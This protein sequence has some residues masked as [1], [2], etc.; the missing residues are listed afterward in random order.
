[1]KKLLL[2][3]RLSLLEFRNR[4]GIFLSVL[5]ILILGN[6]APMIV[7]SLKTSTDQFLNQRSRE[8]LSAD[9]AVSGVRAFT[10]TEKQKLNQQI[11]PFKTAS[12][13]QFLTMA[14][15]QETAMLVEVRAVSE[16]YPL[17][18]SIKVSGSAENA[19]TLNLKN[20]NI[21]WAQADVLDFLKIKVGDTIHIGKADFTIQ[22][23]ILS[24]SVLP[25]SSL[26]FAPR[27]YIGENYVAKTSLNLYGSQIF[28]RI[29]YKLK[30]SGVSAENLGKKLKLYLHDPN[31]YIKTPHDAIEGFGR[32]LD[33][34]SRYLS[35]MT[36]IVFSIAWVSAFYI[37]QS[38]NQDHLKHSA[39]MMSFGGSRL[40]LGFIYLLQA[41]VL[42]ALSFFI[43]LFISYFVLKFLQ[44][45]LGQKL[46]SGFIFHMYSKDLA[47]IFLVSIMTSFC[48]VLTLILKIT[49]LNI[50]ILLGESNQSSE[51]T[52]IL[53]LVLLYLFILTIF[54]SLAFFLMGSESFAAGFVIS[55]VGSALFSLYFG[56]LIF[57]IF[58]L[59]FRKRPGMLR[60]LSINLSRV[61]F[62]QGLCFLA[63]ALIALILN[64][65]PHLMTSLRED[66]S[67]IQG[68]KV[69]ALF[70]FNIPEE[71][72][73]ELKRFSLDSKKE[74]KFISPLILARLTEVNG[75][76]PKEDFL[77]KFPVR[78][79]YRNAM[80]AS[81]K[82]VDGE[83]F[84]KVLGRTSYLSMEQG[85]AERWGFKIGD[86][87]TFDVSG[88][89]F[90][91][92][93]LNLRRVRW[94]DFN[95]NFYFEFQNGVL[96]DA[97]KTWLANVQIE[98]D[99][100]TS[101]FENQLIK[102]FPDISI[103]DIRKSIEQISQ[104]V[105]ALILPAEKLSSLSALLSLLILGFVIWHHL[106]SRIQEIEIVKIFGSNPTQ[107]ALLFILE[108]MLLGLCALI[109]G[110]VTGMAVTYFVCLKFLKVEPV[111]AWH[112][113]LRSTLACLAV[114][115]FVSFGLVLRIMRKKD[116]SASAL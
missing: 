54:V 94:S 63:I 88:I 106:L 44:A 43:A 103:I 28:H 69:P 11:D 76:P 110:S 97:P 8:I 36:L 18:G 58:R 75:R 112:E 84:P 109:T 102:L 39:I 27:I 67:P 101:Q 47:R 1:L 68:Q 25:Q 92:E 71:R 55:L 96:N 14:R 45:S 38:L 98:N 79:S 42:S 6:L 91:A 46:P 19:N 48:Y 40:M 29:Y 59:I 16:N 34:F 85:F 105:N 64:I 33:F 77:L 7:S 72:L 80:I 32:F 90:K 52:P 56:K 115:F 73:E 2:I 113:L 70:L 9:L 111:F 5:I 100:D 50:Q 31:I 116:Q 107:V 104:I 24:D 30:D 74:L 26:S 51:K 57:Y 65:V 114:L 41:F 20:K 15:S 87:M 17:F 53:D 89:P 82:L 37:F 95:P 3:S 93:V 12:E 81:E 10:D 83:P 78:V 22:A 86:V 35:V 99:K 66:I 21:A 23:Q 62:A 49:R 60:V 4:L 108:Y 61:R 13:I